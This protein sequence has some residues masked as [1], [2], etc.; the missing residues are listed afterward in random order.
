MPLSVCLIS[1]GTNQP[2]NY[3]CGKPSQT[4]VLMNSCRNGKCVAQSCN[5]P[6]ASFSSHRQCIL[7]SASPGLPHDLWLPHSFHTEWSEGAVW[8]PC[9]HFLQALASHRLPGKA[10]DLAFC[11]VFTCVCFSAS[12][13]SGKTFQSCT[14]LGLSLAYFLEFPL[15]LSLVSEGDNPLSCLSWWQN[16]SHERLPTH[17]KGDSVMAGK[18]H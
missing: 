7:C 17:R 3:I 5:C 13:P 2:R 10:L 16:D 8:R 4:F 15:P 18:V 9:F 14:D 11:M 1:L 12:P 6:Y